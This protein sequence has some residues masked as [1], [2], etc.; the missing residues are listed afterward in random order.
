MDF[1]FAH[2]GASFEAPENTIPAF[3]KALEQMC[4]A[5]ELDVHCTKDGKLIVCHDEQ[6]NRT[7][8]GT[9]YIQEQTLVELKKRDAGT[10]FDERF[11]GTTLP[12]LEEVLGL[13]TKEIWINIEIKNVPF[14]YKGIE[15]KVMKALR[16]FNFGDNSIISSFDHYA[17]KKV[18]EIEPKTKIGVLF[19]DHLIQPWNYIKMV[20]LNA[21]SIHPLASSVTHEYVQQS[22]QAGFKVFAYT[23]DERKTFQSLK[24]MQ[25]DGIFTNIPARFL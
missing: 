2:R 5:I 22:H 9:G 25:M 19:G 3:Q 10:W 20:G 12:T 1:I 16:Y 15:E 4:T 7:T 18:Q 24:D 8:D 21:F 17:L 11:Q 6:I 23:V 14:F 13:C